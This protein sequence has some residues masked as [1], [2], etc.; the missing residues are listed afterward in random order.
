MQSTALPAT[1]SPLALQINAWLRDGIS[2]NEKLRPWKTDLVGTIWVTS[3]VVADGRLFIQAPLRDMGVDTQEALFVARLKSVG[4]EVRYLLK[5]VEAAD[6]QQE[7]AEELQRH[8]R[9]KSGWYALDL[10]DLSSFL[11]SGEWDTYIGTEGSSPVRFLRLKIRQTF[12]PG[13]I[14]FTCGLTQ[15][16]VDR[17]VHCGV[18]LACAATTIRACSATR[19]STQDRRL[20]L[21]G[22]V[23]LDG[24]ASLISGLGS[25]VLGKRGQKG[26]FLTGQV[27]IADG[28]W[29]GEVDITDITEGFSDFYLRMPNVPRDIRITSTFDPVKYFFTAV[30]ERRSNIAMAR[31]YH[32]V[33]G[34][35]AV[36]TDVAPCHAE[37]GKVWVSGKTITITG[38]M[39]GDAGMGAG[40]ARAIVVHR[41]T[42][43]ELAFPIYRTGRD[44]MIEWRLDDARALPG[45]GLWDL[46]LE[47]PSGART[48]M[49]SHMDRFA[50]KKDRKLFPPVLAGIGGHFASI[51]PYY[52]AHDQ[53]SVNVRPVSSRARI[54]SAQLLPHG[55][56][57][58]AEIVTNKVF[59]D[60][61][62]VPPECDLVLHDVQGQALRMKARVKADPAGS[63]KMNLELKVRLTRV[64]QRAFL[65]RSGTGELVLD[66]NAMQGHG[67][68]LTLA[69]GAVRRGVTGFV[70]QLRRMLDKITQKHGETIYARMNRLLPVKKRTVVF[71]SFHGKSYADSPR[72][73]Y[74]ALL[75]QRPEMQSVWVLEDLNKPIPGNARKVRPR[76]LSYYYYLARA[77]YFV[78]NA[79]FPDFLEKRPGTVHLQTWHG[80]PLKRIGLHVDPASPGYEINAGAAVRKRYAR[81][82]LLLA[83]NAYSSGIFREAFD[84]HGEMMECGYP[85][86]D[87][88]AD[89][90][91]R[92]AIRQKLR[93]GFS[94][95]AE[96]RSVLYAPTWRDDKR[97][98]SSLPL[99]LRK[100]HAA[101]DDGHVMFFRM[102][103]EMSKGLLDVS[104]AAPFAR[105]VSSY[106]DANDLLAMADIL[107]TDYSSVMFDFCLTGRPMI[108]FAYDL[109][110]YD[111]KLRGFYLDFLEMAPGP[112]VKTQEELYQAIRSVD[113]WFPRYRERYSRFQEQ[114]ASWE[115]GRA[116][117]RAAERLVP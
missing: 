74:E 110:H 80:T 33:S 30:T 114:F 25:L 103:H 70:P 7:I 3:L 20:I 108:F 4:D 40:P 13:S 99:S 79:N 29:S 67:I 73:I 59:T 52:T 50:G 100:A 81:W 6:L 15:I 1:Y 56:R 85:R 54:L 32:T 87:I 53:I 61:I 101:L 104:A 26:T 115:D 75:T 16:T 35:L 42:R 65:T 106:D 117:A 78:N 93:A 28:R 96:K 88:L 23:D 112:I 60:R 62:I 38:T 51:E 55:L 37:V 72:R 102:H 44:F 43:D 9:P 86:N 92:E 89:P 39:V 31:P 36:K 82:D 105:N 2:K 95:P 24:D 18:F 98:S 111:S 48:R 109:A 27:H 71:Q 57:A 68:R 46:F 107:V 58:T 66:L 97:G 113:E 69:P 63:F 22:T 84:F 11:F 10:A 83:P 94:V 47:V 77:R 19:I 17:T 76:S 41:E 34:H 90:E 49:A 64:E 21:S 14:S 5:R 8:T 12:F 116:S 91:R 45:F